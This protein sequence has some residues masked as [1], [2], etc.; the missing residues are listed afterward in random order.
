MRNYKEMAYDLIKK[1]IYDGNGF[2]D[3]EVTSYIE[4]VIECAEEMEKE[5]LDNYFKELRKC[6]GTKGERR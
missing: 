1:S 5:Q 6:M 4:G 3:G 2:T